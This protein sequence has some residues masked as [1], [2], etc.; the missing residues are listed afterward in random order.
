MTAGD[1]LATICLTRCIAPGLAFYNLRFSPRRATHCLTARKYAKSS[2]DRTARSKAAGSLRC[3]RAAR[4][5]RRGERLAGL[6][7]PGSPLEEPR[8]AGARGASEARFVN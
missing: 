7:V 1:A 6:A 2:P 5:T 3:S 8:S 4:R